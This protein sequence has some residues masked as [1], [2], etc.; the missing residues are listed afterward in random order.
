[1][2]NLKNLKTFEEFTYDE[3]SEMIDEKIFGRGGFFGGLTFEQAKEIAEKRFGTAIDIAKKFDSNSENVQKAKKKQQEEDI[4]YRS[5]EESIY[6]LLLTD[7]E[8]KNIKWDSSLGIY[9]DPKKYGIKGIGG[10]TVAGKSGSGV[11]KKRN[12]ELDKNK[13]K[14]ENWNR[15][16]RNNY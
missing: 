4:E 1:M 3:N 14:N 2:K 6:D 10:S 12:P 15:H 7:S 5:A 13:P 16:Y 8:I 11:N 9:I